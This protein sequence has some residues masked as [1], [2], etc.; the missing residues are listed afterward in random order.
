MTRVPRGLRDLLYQIV[1]GRG[2]ATPAIAVIVTESDYEH[3][4][5]LQVRSAAACEAHARGIQ[6]LQQNL[7]PN[8]SAQYEQC[9]YFD[10]IGGET[11]R[12][13]RIRAGCQMNVEQLDKKGRPKWALCFAPEGELVVG[14]VMLAQKLALELFESDTLKVANKSHPHPDLLLGPIA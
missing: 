3:F 4:G 5:R 7:S 1:C 10:V 6:L 14:D 9:G 12:R 8:Q 13:Y 2:Q 11:G